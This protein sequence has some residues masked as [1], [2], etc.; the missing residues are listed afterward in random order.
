MPQQE[1]WVKRREHWLQPIA[2][3]EQ[4]IEDPSR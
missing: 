4:A 1:G 2:G 3:I